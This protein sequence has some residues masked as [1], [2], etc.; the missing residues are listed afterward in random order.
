[1][2]GD[3]AKSLVWLRLGVAVVVPHSTVQCL[4]TWL[5]VRLGGGAVVDPSLGPV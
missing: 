5:S 2:N 4:S 3:G 1:M